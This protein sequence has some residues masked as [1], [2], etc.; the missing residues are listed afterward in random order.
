MAEAGI[1][2][3]T[4]IHLGAAWDD[5]VADFM[6]CVDSLQEDDPEWDP[7]S[8]VD[9]AAEGL[10]DEGETA[11]LRAALLAGDNPYASAER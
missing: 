6:R 1:V 4:R 10:P 8:L 3:P 7:S 5:Y 9:G 11:A 2:E